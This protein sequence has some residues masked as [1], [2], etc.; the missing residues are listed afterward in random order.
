[1]HDD[2][3]VRNETSRRSH[4]KRS[5]LLLSLLLAAGACAGAA[6]LSPASWPV[7]AR[8]QAERTEA[9][10]WS[11]RTMRSFRSQNGL[12]SAV[13]SPVAVLAGLEALRRGGNAADAAATVALTQMTRELGSVVSY[14]GIM[15]L[16][17]YDAKTHQV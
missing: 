17:Y 10:T 7:K 6:D 8:E 15:T 4:M 9:Q 5:S 2:V 14:A 11:P 12:I 3:A 1:M 16:L 13:G